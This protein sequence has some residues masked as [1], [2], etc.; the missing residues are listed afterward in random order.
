M[1]LI[2]GGDVAGYEAE[3]G[4]RPLDYSANINPLG[5]PDGVRR[6]VIDALDQ[7]DAYPDP[8]CRKLRGAIAQAEQAAPGHI[9]CGNGAADLIFRLVLAARPRHALVTAPTFAEYEQALAL[10]DCRVTRHFL[11]ERENFALTERFLAALQ[12]DVDMVFLCNPNN[13][14]G[15][16]IKPALLQKI[17]GICRENGI[18]LVVDE[19][20]NAFLDEPG[21]N[22][23]K[24]LLEANP[25]LLVLKAFTKLYAMAGIRLGYCLCADEALLEQMARCGQPWGVS[26][27]A[28]AAGVAALAEQDYVQRTRVLIAR[29]RGWMRQAL[30][31]QKQRVLGS[32]ANYIF[33]QT[34]TPELGEKMRRCGV[35]IRSCANYPGLDGSWY[36]CAVRSHEENVRMI[37]ALKRARTL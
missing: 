32:A 12:P 6:A 16:V 21:K 14:T 18:R 17:V 37:E 24:P 19:C 26:S 27:L 7:A 5:L 35:M 22:T 20:F 29:E 36:R 8:L 28:Q 33:F 11:L 9:L 2:H 13:P 4:T 34:D 25:H 23:V 10:V 1:K 30:A 31:A 3:Y 15:Q